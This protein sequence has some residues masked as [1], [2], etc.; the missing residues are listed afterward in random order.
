MPTRISEGKFLEILTAP[1]A[2]GLP[3]ELDVYDGG[4]P[5]T[6][7]ATLENAWDAALQ[8]EMSEVGSGIF[9]HLPQ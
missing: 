7:L 6:M 5:G 4:N 2:V 9:E 8:V 3:I 1:A